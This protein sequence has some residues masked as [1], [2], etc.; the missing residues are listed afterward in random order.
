MF[1]DVYFFYSSET[2]YEKILEIIKSKSKPYQI[3]TNRSGLNVFLKNKGEKVSMIDEAIASTGK[4]GEEVNKR[5]K[6]N[7]LLYEKELKDFKYNDITIFSG[8]D[9]KIL[10]THVLYAKLEMI[11]ERKINSIFVFEGFNPIYFTLIKKANELGFHCN[12]SITLI[13]NKLNQNIKYDDDVTILNRKSFNVNQSKNY[14]KLSLVDKN[15]KEKINT[16]INYSKKILTLGIKKKIQKYSLLTDEE[17]LDK[18]FLQVEN[19]INKLNLKKIEH[20][21]FFTA[22]RDDIYIKPWGP[23]FEKFHNSNKDF[24]II[25]NDIA[26]TLILSKEKLPHV[27]IFEEVKLLEEKIISMDVG[28]KFNLFLTEKLNENN[29]CESFPDLFTDIIYKAQKTIALTIIINHIFEKEKIKSIIAGAVGEILENTAIEV[30]KKFNIPSFSM[31]SVNISP[32]FPWFSNW[33][34]TDKIFVHGTNGKNELINLGYK[35]EQIIISGNPQIDKFLNKNISETKKLLKARY[36]IDSK[37]KL[38]VIAMS[39]WH[40][41]DEIWMSNIIKF[42]NEMNLEIIIKVHPKFKSASNEIGKSKI[43]EIRKKCKGLKYLIS[44][45]LDIFSL[46]PATDL[47]I[48][49]SSHVGILGILFGKKLIAINFSNERYDDNIIYLSLPQNS[50][51]FIENFNE[52]IKTISEILIDEINNEKMKKIKD[53]VIRGHNYYNDNKS[54][55]RIFNILVEG[56]HS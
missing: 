29:R 36:Q 56:N 20:V 50:N 27:S 53:S 2:S 19:K 51:Y 44:Y 31:L 45:D 42:C 47:V 6:R 32:A 15:I 11:L 30:S 41:D 9:Y 3:F 24:L 43:I 13:K 49:E 33:F 17:I 28:K 7:Y 46:L 21:F 26:T 34:K 38:I 55:K 18:L 48:T 14:F 39:K 40:I 23:I 10:A 16:T 8:F 25:T 5:A 52:L 4:I 35:D 22:A 37:K 1:C 54:S 12:N